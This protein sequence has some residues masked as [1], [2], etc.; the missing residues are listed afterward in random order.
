MESCAGRWILQ[1]DLVLLQRIYA[2][3]A[4]RIDFT[5]QEILELVQTD[6]ELREL[7]AGVYHK[8]FRESEPKA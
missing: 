5:W 8:D 4:P 6:P 1:V 7:N 3:F 2:S